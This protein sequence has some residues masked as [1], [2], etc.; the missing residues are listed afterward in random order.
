MGTFKD[1]T[2]QQ[3]GRLTVLKQDGWYTH[4][5]S[6]KRFAK[7][8]CICS[9]DGKTVSIASSSLISGKT[10][11]CG[12]Y[13]KERARVQT[14]PR[15]DSTQTSVNAWYASIRNGALVRNY[16]FNISKEEAYEVA[17][18]PCHYCGV[19][20]VEDQSARSY[21]RLCKKRDLKFSY[22][23]YKS[24]VLRLNGLDRVDNIVSC[25]MICNR[26]KNDMTEIK[27]RAWVTRLMERNN[28]EILTLK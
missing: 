13:Q 26:A 8:S 5:S 10:T 2:G 12:C 20:E 7:W 11:S 21:L 25:C 18:K 9:C 22:T 4:A 28:I 16:T 1:L 27:F 15:K 14:G 3:V 17:S 23:F 6:G 19:I 24:K